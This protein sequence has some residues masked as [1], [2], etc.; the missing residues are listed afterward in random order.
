M[1]IFIS[2]R[3]DFGYNNLVAHD[4]AISYLLSSIDTNKGSG[5]DRIPPTFI[6]NCA[7][8]LVEPLKLIYAQSLATNK[9]PKLWKIGQ[10]TPIHKSGNKND[11]NN[12]RGVNV[13]SNF[14]K[15][16]EQLIYNQ[17]KFIIFPRI[18]PN[19]H[20]FLPNRNINTNLMTLT[21]HILAAFEQKAQ[22]DLF[23]GDI[24]AAFD[25]VNQKLLIRK[26]AK[27][28]LSNN[29][30]KW[31]T[32]YFEDRKQFVKIGNSLSNQFNVN[33]SVGQGSVL[34]PILFLIFFNDSD[35]DIND[36]DAF[37]L[38][39]ADDKKIGRIVKNDG[40]TKT[41]QNCIN[42]FFMWCK[43]NG[44]NVNESKC[45]VMT[46]S[47]KKIT[48]HADYY[49][50][51]KIIERTDKI[52][53][54]GVIFDSK[55]SFIRHMEYIIN[56]SKAMLSFVKRQCYKTFDIDVAKLLYFALVRSN[57]E[58]ASQIWMPFHTNHKKSIESVQKNLVKFIHNDNSAH[59]PRNE[60]EL[61]PYVDRCAE[62]NIQTLV[63][64]RIN[65]S[66]YFIHDIITG[67]IK[68]ENLREEIQFTTLT[69]STRHW[70]FIR[71]SKCRLDISDNSPFRTACRLYNL[72][73]LFVDTTI[74][75]SQF[76]RKI[77]L[78]PDNIFLDYARH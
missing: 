75:R 22:L 31:F 51:N 25:A 19:Q 72:A 9:Y 33:S 46:F 39:F 66:I 16:F 2:Q 27:F 43:K 71:L 42:K 70:Q 53:D 21:S 41:L 77:M 45:K 78:L 65:C 24:A 50:N 1:D 38:D 47:N 68:S 63:R 28:P 73:A 56:K 20:G 54:L 67:K 55:M 32:S 52:R 30:L 14:A 13:L 34:G 35:A 37:I 48:I 76:R 49:I 18:S 26:I 57:L 23:F 74:P 29:V 12:Y 40:D 61:R 64:R 59:N 3:N 4:D 62:L 17:L 10:I 5:F 58:F 69:R 8:N 7:N 11:M 60:Y 36:I 15:I 44:L 6:R